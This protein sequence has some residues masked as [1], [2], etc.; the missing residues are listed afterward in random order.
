MSLNR[1][2]LRVMCF[3]TP[4]DVV[5]LCDV[6]SGVTFRLIDVRLRRVAS[7][8]M[9]EVLNLDAVT[10]DMFVA[11]HFSA[12]TRCLEHDQAVALNQRNKTSV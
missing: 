4:C 8:S 1:V 7:I 5:S 9:L 3:S 6:V 11:N 12:A 10:N 2:A